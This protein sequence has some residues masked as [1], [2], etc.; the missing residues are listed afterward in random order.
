[1]NNEAKVRRSIKSVVLGKAK[2][3][4]HGDIEGARAKR[5]A[6]EESTAG[7]RKCGRKR[8]SP[9]LEADTLEPKPQA[10]RADDIIFTLV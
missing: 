7:K 5:A 1:M 9:V 4:S 8:K 2:V 10:A 3:T 6:Q